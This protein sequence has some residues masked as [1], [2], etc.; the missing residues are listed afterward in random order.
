MTQKQIDDNAALASM[1]SGILEGLGWVRQEQDGRLLFT[2]SAYYSPL[3]PPASID[4]AFWYEDTKA[5]QIQRGLR[6]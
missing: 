5:T 2:H 1:V 3:C 4:E 6:K